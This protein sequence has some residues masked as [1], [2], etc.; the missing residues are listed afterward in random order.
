MKS[1]SWQFSLLLNDLA[2]AGAEPIGVMLTILLPEHAE[3]SLLKQLMQEL[4]EGCRGGVTFRLWA[5]IP[6]L[7]GW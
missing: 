5:D 2:S 7:P 6:R 4:E 3:E 1:E